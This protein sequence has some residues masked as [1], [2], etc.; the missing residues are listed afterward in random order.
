MKIH[1]LYFEEKH[2][3]SIREEI[4]P[5]LDKGQ[6][7]V[8]TR[9]SAISSGS[10]MLI[11]RGLFPEDMV[12][13]LTLPGLSGNL[14]FPLKYG[15]SMVGEIL[16]TGPGLDRGLSG[17]KVFLFHPHQDYVVAD[18]EY[19]LEIPSQLDEQ[20]ALFFANMESA[21][22]FVMDGRPMVGER[23]VIIGQGVVGLLTTALNSYFP[24]SRLIT[25][26]NFEKRRHYSV[27]LGA[28]SSLDPRSEEF[29]KMM[30]KLLHRGNQ[31]VAEGAD[32]I[33]ELSG[34]PEALNLALQFSGFQGR[35]IVGSWYGNKKAKVDL[36][37]RFHRRQMN[38]HSSQVSILHPSLSGRWNKRRRYELVWDMLKRFKPSTLISHR[39]PFGD[40]RLA[41]NLLDKKPQETLQ[42]ILTYPE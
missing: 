33:Y 36:G 5:P 28:N 40:A 3:I 2:C 29:G 26:D 30:D 9:F 12:A 21:V 6:V 25:V 11:Y 23:V 10:E 31:D 1:S 22:S 38:I 20:D 8:K 24:L 41:Y 17:K 39:I 14:T 18:S 37:S 7:L 15:Y 34:N 42:V 13:D 4:L 32:L 16:K 35:I 19:I 27:L